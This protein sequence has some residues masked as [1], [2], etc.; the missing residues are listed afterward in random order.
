MKEWVSERLTKAMRERVREW[1][2][3]RVTKILNTHTQL[4][5]TPAPCSPPLHSFAGLQLPSSD[6]L[7]DPS[8]YAKRRF[9]CALDNVRARMVLTPKTIEVRLLS[10]VGVSLQ[11]EDHLPA[12]T[13]LLSAPPTAPVPPDLAPGCGCGGP[14]KTDPGPPPQPH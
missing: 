1:V 13:R 3:E 5:F 12:T 8:V 6:P 2:S 14:A 9:R 11:T 7:S 4:A 10:S